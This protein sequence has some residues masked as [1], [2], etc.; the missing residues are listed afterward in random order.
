MKINEVLGNELA[1]V[2]GRTKHI[3]TSGQHRPRLSTT[4]KQ[5]VIPRLAGQTSLFIHISIMSLC[6]N[7]FESEDLQ[8]SGQQ[9]SPRVTSWHHSPHNLL[10]GRQFMG[11]RGWEQMIDLG[12]PSVTYCRVHQPL[13]WQKPRRA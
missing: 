12:A 1:M 13:G 11:G 3:L 7:R 5:N 6:S 9:T 10:G 2:E 8:F 4:A